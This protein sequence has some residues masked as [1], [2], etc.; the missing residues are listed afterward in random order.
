M[1]FQYFPQQCTNKYKKCPKD[2]PKSAK[3]VPNI[4]QEMSNILREMPNN[5]S[6]NSYKAKRI[7]N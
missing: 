4:F 3:H 7:K 5:Q 2:V 1:E 6:L